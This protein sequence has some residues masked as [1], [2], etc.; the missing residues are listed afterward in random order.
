MLTHLLCEST[1]ADK[2]VTIILLYSLY[3]ADIIFTYVNLYRLKK[4]MPKKYVNYEFNF[5]IR[6]LIKRYS[7]KTALIYSSTVN[8]VLFTLISFYLNPGLVIG[9]LSTIVFLIHLPNYLEI[10]KRLKKH[11]T[12]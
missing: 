1:V 5:I 12:K 7:L 2:I 9:V 4:L 10:K 3:I 6:F 11:R 8:L